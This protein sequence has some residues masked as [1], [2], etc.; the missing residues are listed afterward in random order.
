MK[1]VQSAFIVSVIVSL[2][3]AASDRLRADPNRV[4]EE[5]VTGVIGESARGYGTADSK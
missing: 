5:R 4:T 1:R 3:L 2:G